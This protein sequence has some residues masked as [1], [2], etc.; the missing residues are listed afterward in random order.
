VEFDFAITVHVKL[1]ESLLQLHPLFLRCQVRRHECHCSMP[2]FRLSREVAQIGQRVKVQVRV[3]LCLNLLFDPWVV[4]TFSRG[5]ALV[6]VKVHH[7]AN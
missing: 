2:K 6:V 7:F 1:L 3:E 4:E 5:E